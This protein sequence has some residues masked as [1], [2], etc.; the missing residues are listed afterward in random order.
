MILEI[1][2]FGSLLDSLSSIKLSGFRTE[3]GQRLSNSQA[4]RP[5]LVRLSKMKITYGAHGVGIVVSSKKQ[6]KLKSK[7]QEPFILIGSHPACADIPNFIW[8]FATIF[9]SDHAGSL[10]KIKGLQDVTISITESNC[11]V[12]KLLNTK[13]GP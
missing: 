10:Y 13:C 11:F 3:V 7:A 12:L 8:K 6:H 2:S 5:V 9:G 4:S 1:L